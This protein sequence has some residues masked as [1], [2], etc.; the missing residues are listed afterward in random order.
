MTRGME[1]REQK[2][3]Q[4]SAQ[5]SAQRNIDKL[6]SGL[7][8]WRGE[9]LAEVR[10]LIHDVLPGVRETWKWM[11]SPVWEQDGIV[12]V[13]NAHKAKVKLT[14][15]RGALLADPDGLFNAGLGGKAWRAIDLHEHDTLDPAAFRALV[16]EAAALNGD[17]APGQVAG[18]SSGRAPDGPAVK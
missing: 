1:M 4:E 2:S 15:P 6:I 9:L 8:D 5:E 7:G 14:F 17:G 10:D 16:R 12:A 3:A 11:G 13:G 18:R